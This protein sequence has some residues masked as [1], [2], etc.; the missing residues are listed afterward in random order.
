[1]LGR[2][3]VLWE[4]LSSSRRT[5]KATYTNNEMQE[6]NEIVLRI[7]LGKLAGVWKFKLSAFA[8][9]KFGLFYNLIKFPLN[10]HLNECIKH[11]LLIQAL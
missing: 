3:A 1:M 9:L 10:F 4:A 2:W 5:M 11:W 7:V 8:K 6:N